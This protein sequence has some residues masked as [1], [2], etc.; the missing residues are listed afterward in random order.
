[1]T[2]RLANATSIINEDAHLAATDLDPELRALAG[3]TLLITGAGGFLL[4]YMLD[5]VAAWN[6]LG[7]A[8]PCH[9][10]AVDNHRRQRERDVADAR[11]DEGG[12]AE[13]AVSQHQRDL[14]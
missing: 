14:R 7:S 9:V 6:H 2:L 12:R 11:S 3:T 8:A 4:S 1:M 10:I 13:H 5:V